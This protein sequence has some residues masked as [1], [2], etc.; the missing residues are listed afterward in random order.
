L[1]SEKTNNFVMINYKHLHYFWMVAREGSIS[2]ASEILHLTP[3]TVSG[4]LTLLE[5]NLGVVLF[6]RA[7]R[8]LELTEA[9]RLVLSYAEEMFSLGGELEEMLRNLPSNRPM[10]FKVGV[11]DVVPKS[12]TYRLLAPS[13]ELPG[14]VR[15]ICRENNIENLL[16]ELAVH[17]VDLVISDAPIPPHINVRGFSHELGE[18]GIS[19]CA[20]PQLAAKLRKGFPKSL[21]GA[22]MLMP[23]DNT[24]VHRDL[25]KWLDRSHI[26]PYIV[27]EFDDSALMKAFGQAGIGAFIVPTPIVKEI[28]QQFGVEAFGSTDKVRKRFYAIS[29]ERRISHPAVAAV[30]ESAREWLVL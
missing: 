29:V 5:Q 7:G 26:Q 10:V 18:C 28:E 16:A 30:T 19:F 27:G 11:A 25:L 21:N 20:V 24:V 22:P 23:G 17:R 14:Q 1:I 6:R 3:Q 2:R 15:I 9:G 12:I 4:Q 13:L 8:N